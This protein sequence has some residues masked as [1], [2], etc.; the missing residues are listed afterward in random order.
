MPTSTP[1][2]IP[3]NPT[4]THAP[5]TIPPRWS[6]RIA[7]LAPCT[8][9]NVAIHQFAI[10]ALHTPRLDS[11]MAIHLPIRILTGHPHE[12]QHTVPPLCCAVIRPTTGVAIT[13]YK[14]LQ[15]DPLLQDTWAWAI[16]KEFGNLAQHQH[17]RHRHN[18]RALTRPNKKNST[19]PHR[20][21]HTNRCQLS[22]TKIGSQP[23]LLNRR[24][25]SH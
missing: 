21:V 18:L 25:K 13:K 16:G 12:D 6:E 23:H 7:L 9:S 24:W 3:T 14:H 11:N 2:A 20:H 8:Y 22:A 4:Q 5:T 10:A 17:T 1:T 15:K 19:R